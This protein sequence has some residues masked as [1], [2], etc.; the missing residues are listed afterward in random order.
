MLAYEDPG[1]AL[2]FARK[3]ITQAIKSSRSLTQF[4]GLQR[5][6]LQALADDQQE[7][8]HRADTEL[9][10]KAGCSYCCHL[11]VEVFAHEVLL[12]HQG[13]TTMP[14]VAERQAVEARLRAN[15]QRIEA[16]SKDEHWVTNIPCA[17]LSDGHCSLHGIRPL[18]CAR[19]HSTDVAACRRAHD[20]P[21]GQGDR[22]PI[23]PEINL[24][25]GTVMQAMAYSL[26]QARL[27]HRTYELNAVLVRV[28]DD[29]TLLNRW[30][31]GRP[32]VPTDTV[33]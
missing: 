30:R 32:L 21:V 24:Q 28:F 7:I 5:Q 33:E 19:Y 25:G 8:L 26:K 1:Q 16:I 10:C 6:L 9:P 2:R 4:V 3:R 14:D 23:L 17:L 20:D 27:D 22:R 12:L 31:R 18:T 15:A 13:I 11:R 29:P